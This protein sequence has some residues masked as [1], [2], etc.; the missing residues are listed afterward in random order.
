VSPIEGILALFPATPHETKLTSALAFLYLQYSIPLAL[1]PDDV[2]DPLCSSV[3]QRS[4]RADELEE[5]HDCTVYG[6]S[7]SCGDT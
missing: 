1:G 6:G 5:V 4:V 7:A 3:G 2:I